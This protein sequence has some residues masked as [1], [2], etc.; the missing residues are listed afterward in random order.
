MLNSESYIQIHSDII[1]SQIPAL[2][3]NF[4]FPTHQ[5][6]HLSITPITDPA[7]VT[8]QY[9]DTRLHFSKP[10]PNR[11]TRSF[12]TKHLQ[13][14]INF[15]STENPA[16]ANLLTDTVLKPHQFFPVCR[17]TL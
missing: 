2:I 1:S 11:L 9:A 5:G 17:F 4:S 16:L 7:G 14:Y 15:I 13:T 10:T 8:D 12:I 6:V 3:K